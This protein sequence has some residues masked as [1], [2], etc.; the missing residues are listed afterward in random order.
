MSR[1]FSPFFTTFLKIRI[2]NETRSYGS[3]AAALDTQCME[4][5]EHVIY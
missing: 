2:S 5:R 1:K 4:V 3:S